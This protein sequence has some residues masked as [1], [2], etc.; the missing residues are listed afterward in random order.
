MALRI[1]HNISAMTGHRNL[2]INDRLLG[3]SLEKLSSGMKINR[4]AD[5]PASLIIS[6]QMRAQVAGLNQAVDNAETAIGMVQTTESALTEVTNLLTGMRQLAIHAANE[7]ANDAN[8]LEADQ[9]ELDNSLN[10]IDRL[11]RSASFGVK[12]LLDGSQGANGV[13][14]GEGLEFIS[15]DPATRSSP[16]EGYAVK[17]QQLGSRTEVSGTTALT[18][19]MVD[20]GEEL[21]ITEGGRT[22]SYRSQ[23]GDTVSQSLGKLRNE[24][25]ENGL[26][27]DMFVSEDNILTL[28]HKEYGRDHSFAVSSASA[29]V[30]S[31]ESRVMQAAVEGKD[32]IGT[33]AG[34]VAY[35]QGNILTGAA[36]TKVEGLKIRYN[37]NKITAADADDSAERAGNVA[38]YQNSLQFQVG[39]NVGQTVTVSLVNTNTRVLG[40]G[41]ENNSGYRSLRD[42][43]I[44]N[45]QGAEDA[46]R[47]IDKSIDEVNVTRAQLGAFQKNTLESNLR[48]LRIGAEELTSAESVIRDA[49]MAKEVADYT[50]N[51]IMV[52]SS[53]AMLAQANQTPRTVLRLLD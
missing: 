22:V 17:V 9:L 41:V 10:T 40:R 32:I 53:T 46:Q 6:E 31:S 33:I 35:G 3:K 36:G 5:G 14:M 47:L 2:A 48:Q 20:N 7:G 44:R 24:I 21:T 51:S 16:V 25:K 42:L 50:R 37:G 49:D 43:D 12:R 38:V 26:Q 18:Q 15:A 34:E 1:N 4:A 39:A 28:R 29:G 19:E 23:K 45:G 13:G 8:M 27:V 11:T 30:L 52:Q